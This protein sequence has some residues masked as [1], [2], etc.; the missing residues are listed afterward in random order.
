MSK[1]IKIA[2][3]NIGQDLKNNEI[4]KDSYKYIKEQIKQNEIDIIYHLPYLN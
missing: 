3:W 1:I 2:T 4:N